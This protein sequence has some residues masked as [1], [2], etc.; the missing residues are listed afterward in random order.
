MMCFLCTSFEKISLN[1]LDLLIFVTIVVAV[2]VLTPFLNVFSF[3]F[4]YLTFCYPLF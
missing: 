2:C 3:L 1:V 4:S